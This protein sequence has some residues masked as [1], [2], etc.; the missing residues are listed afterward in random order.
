MNEHDAESIQDLFRSIR[1]CRE[2]IEEC[3]RKIRANERA[4]VE[5]RN[6]FDSLE[7]RVDK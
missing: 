3:L 4:I 6:D 1:E 5:L 2:R 7:R